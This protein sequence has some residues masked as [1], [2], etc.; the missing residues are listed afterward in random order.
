MKNLIKVCKFFNGKFNKVERS[1]Y[2]LHSL[3]C[4]PK[5]LN[6]FIIS[7]TYKKFCQSIIFDGFETCYLSRSNLK[8]LNIRQNILIK[9]SLGLTKFLRTTPLLNALQIKSVEELYFKH[10]ILLFKQFRFNDTTKYVLDFLLS[11]YSGL[12]IKCPKESC[13][14]EIIATFR[15][16]KSELRNLLY[17]S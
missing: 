11:H 16:L 4:K 12:N 7:K 10:K 13:I 9:N 14:S 8:E 5:G 2:S 15:T 3:S 1:F 6:P 17:K